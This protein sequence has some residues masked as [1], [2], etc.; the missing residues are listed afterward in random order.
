MSRQNEFD[1]NRGLREEPNQ[2]EMRERM[3][4]LQ[5]VVIRQ[6]QLLLQLQ[7][8]QN[9]QQQQPPQHIP[10]NEF[11]FS[12]TPKD[13][14]EQFRRLKP[15]DE[16]HN[17]RAFIN[18]LEANLTLCGNNENLVQFCMGIVAN[19]KIS[20][21]A[22]RRARE[23]QNN[24]SWE[25]IKSKILQE[26]KPKRTYA[27]IFNFCR[28]VKVS[29]LN[30]LFRVFE[31]CKYEINDIYLGDQFNP[32]IYKPENVDRDLVDILLEKI[33]GPIRA[34]IG[35]HETLNDI[36]LKYTKL[37]LLDDTRAIAYNH[38]SNIRY[39]QERNYNQQKP[40][41]NNNIQYPNSNWKN[42]ETNNNPQFKQNSYRKDDFQKQNSGNFETNQYNQNSK[43]RRDHFQKQNRDN[44]QNNRLN[45][46]SSNRTRNSHM[47]VD[48]QTVPNSRQ[49]VM[50]TDNIQR[51]ENF[52]LEAQTHTCP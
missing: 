33:D 22:G 42:S 37:R 10:Y 52:I 28:T 39:K 46:G 9:H 2:E 12:M 6:E 43:F 14:I 23:L 17:P 5:E 31:Q 26:F 40:K 4:Q 15:L 51:D 7:N 1:N 19:E 27:E 49:F 8:Q 18:A 45:E 13:V 21:N 16:K 11:G 47:S 41:T 25:E 44:L 34:H 35:E 50:E 30:E 38:R 36:A 3:Q 32:N 20:G 29:N 24:A 48:Q